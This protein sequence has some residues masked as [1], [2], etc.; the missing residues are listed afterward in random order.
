MKN[1]KFSNLTIIVTFFIWLFMGLFTIAHTYAQD[2]WYPADR[3]IMA[4]DRPTEYT[5]GTPIP[6]DVTIYYHAYMKNK[7][8]SNQVKV[9]TDRFLDTKYTYQIGQEG[10]FYLGAT[11]VRLVESTEYE[12]DISWSDNSE[13]CE[14]GQTFGVTFIYLFSN[15]LRLRK[16]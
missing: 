5:N 1:L 2:T 11:A 16:E 6:S 13:V 9:S 14:N 7:D 4:W 15:P 12:S 10:Q 3:V 8:Q